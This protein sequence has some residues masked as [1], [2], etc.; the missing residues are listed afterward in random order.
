MGPPAAAGGISGPVGLG[1]RTVCLVVSPYSRGGYVCSDVFDHTSLLRFIERRFGVEVP[2][3]SA[4]RRGVTGDFVPA[5][6]SVPDVEVP[7]L[8]QTSLGA[9]VSVVEQA[10]LNALAGSLDRGI[11]YPL[12]AVNSMPVQETVPV[13]RRRSQG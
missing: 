2:N 5:L 7:P 13:R 12:P 10:V 4:W 9:A 3:L 1:F 8:P 6:S 11:P